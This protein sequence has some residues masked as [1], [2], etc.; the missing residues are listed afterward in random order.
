MTTWILTFWLVLP[1][2]TFGEPIELMTFES[3][4]QCLQTLQT[5]SSTADS[6]LARCKQE[7]P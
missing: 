5:V 7:K 3:E 6:W 4:Q 1:N 2:W